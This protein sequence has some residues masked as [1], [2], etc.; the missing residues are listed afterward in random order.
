ML[1]KNDVKILLHV[2]HF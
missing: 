1:F 2:M